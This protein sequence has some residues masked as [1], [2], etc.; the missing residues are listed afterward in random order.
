MKRALLIAFHYPPARGSSGIQR[1]LSFSRYL[2]D[3]GWEPIVLTAHRRAYPQT[4]D[5]QM[6]DVQNVVTKRAFALDTARHLA[7]KGRYFA[8]MAYPD[9]WVSWWLGGVL[10]GIRLV[11]RYKPHVIWSTFPIPTA[12]MIALTLQRW[13]SLPWIADFRDSMTEEHYPTDARKWVIYR[14]IERKALER[15]AYA[16][17]TSPGTV[18]MYHERYPQIPREKYRCI[19]NGFDEISFSRIDS[20]R[21]AV[22]GRQQTVLLHSGLLYP[23]ERDPRPF[24][25]ALKELLAAGAVSAEGLRVTLRASGYEELLQSLIDDAGIGDLVKLEPAV[26]YREAL[27]EMAAADGLLLFQ[28]SN[29]N[30]QIPAKLYEYIRVQ[31]PVLALT[32]PA[33]DT[34]GILAACGIDTIARLDST[35]E[36]K[37]AL[38]KFIGLI[39]RKQAPVPASGAI[40][41]YSRRSQT[42]ELA[43]L[44]D[45]LV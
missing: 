34:A 42:G 5:D 30:H 16:V 37:D 11:R 22:S 13:T 31:R 28:A 19:L 35:V 39:A 41:R 1:T 26:G 4:G 38:L 25:A 44:F 45:A 2:T 15:S 27:S 20:D 14:R 7:I 10:S 3:Y 17:F 32:D 33:G 21:P 40:Q 24:F 29:C 12:H 36:I 9:R 8:P 6:A 23:S 18:N 43:Q